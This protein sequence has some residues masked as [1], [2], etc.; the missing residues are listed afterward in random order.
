[1]RKKDLLNKLMEENKQMEEKLKSNSFTTEELKD[2]L[3]ILPKK[4]YRY[5]K[6]QW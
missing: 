2:R 1:M 3:E 6:H 5:R 4:I